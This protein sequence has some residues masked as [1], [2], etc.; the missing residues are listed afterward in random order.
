MSVHVLSWVLRHSE[1]R[2]GNRLVLLVLADHAAE[3]GTEARPSVA[4]IAREARLSERQ[5][6]YALRHLQ[7]VGAI[8]D[9]REGPKGVRVYRVTMLP[10]G[11]AISAP[12]GAISD[13]EGVQPI[14]PESSLEPSV[15]P[16]TSVAIAPS[17]DGPRTVNRKATTGLERHRARQI[18]NAW[19]EASGQDL[20]SDDWLSKIIM[21]LREYPDATMLDHE[22]I[23]RTALANP[24][25]TGPASPSVVYGNGAQ[26]ERSIEQVRR[27]AT[28]SADMQ[29]ALDGMRRA[30][31]RSR[32]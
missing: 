15:L 7:E 23:I 4:T 3:D 16:S 17:V 25:W 2:L 10:P 20:R 9:E 22:V 27:R 13:A 19:N 12:G 6:Q 24:W 1:E 8:Q 29:E 28:V 18:L 32:A 11:G 31:E 26:F 30:K 5:V 21:R 14:A